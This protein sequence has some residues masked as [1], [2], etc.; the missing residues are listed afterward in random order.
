[1]GF[2]EADE[3]AAELTRPLP[4]TERQL[5]V[6]ASDAI[7]KHGIP[8]IALAGASPCDR[9]HIEFSV[10]AEDL[11]ALSN[12]LRDSEAWKIRRSTS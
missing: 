10:E 12:P 3:S 1:M 6:S 9:E 11:Y 8:S 7:S 4:S 5:E 2:D